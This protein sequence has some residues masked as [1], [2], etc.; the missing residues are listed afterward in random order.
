MGILHVINLLKIANN[1]LPSVQYKYEQLQ[2]Q[3]SGL[4]FDKR[5]AARDFQN[6][7][8][9]II[10]MGKTLDTIKLEC[11]NE[12]A[13]LHVVQQ[14][15]MKQEALVKHFENNNEEYINIVKTI[16][17]KVHNTSSDVKVFLQLALLSI[18]E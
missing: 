1:H 14:E 9:Q 11:Q 18:I 2:K 3:I 15:R 10:S 17:D 5:S 6:L 13:R 16:E 8:D 7:N 4:E 12:K